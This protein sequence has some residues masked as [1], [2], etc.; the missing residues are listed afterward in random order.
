VKHGM[1]YNEYFYSYWIA[2]TIS[3]VLGFGVLYELYCKLFCEL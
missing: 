3:I 1:G 2:Q